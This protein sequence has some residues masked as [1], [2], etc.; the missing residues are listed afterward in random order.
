MNRKM[1]KPDPTPGLPVVTSKKQSAAM[2]NSIPTYSEVDGGDEAGTR[3][4]LE[5]EDAFPNGRMDVLLLTPAR[6]PSTTPRDS[7]AA[8]GVKRRKSRPTLIPDDDD[9]DGAQADVDIEVGKTIGW[10]NVAGRRR[11]SVQNV[12]QRLSR[13][14]EEERRLEGNEGRRHSMAV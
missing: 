1:R 13:A 8:T 2:S 4:S 12:S 14:V 7:I 9:S 6:L 11:S 3:S 10:V 5:R